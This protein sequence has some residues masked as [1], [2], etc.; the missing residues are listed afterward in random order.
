VNNLLRKTIYLTDQEVFNQGQYTL[1]EYCPSKFLPRASDFNLF[2]NGFRGCI[3]KRIFSRVFPFD[4]GAEERFF[5]EYRSKL[6]QSIKSKVYCK[7]ICSKM[8]R[9]KQLFNNFNTFLWGLLFFL[10]L[11]INL[12]GNNKFFDFFEYSNNLQVKKKTYLQA[13]IVNAFF[14]ILK[15]FYYMNVFLSIDR[16]IK[17]S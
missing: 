16:I 4:S 5:L 14:S 3:N 15:N 9:T 13:K 17:S 8:E 2:L 7:W 10:I 11:W 6:I 12:I 1:K